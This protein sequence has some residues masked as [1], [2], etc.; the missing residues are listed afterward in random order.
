MSQ[1]KRFYNVFKCPK[2]PFGCCELVGSFDS[3]D[4]AERCQEE[5]NKEIDNDCCFLLIHP[6]E[7]EV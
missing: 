4:E 6:L 3:K 1:K 7:Y 2:T 5:K